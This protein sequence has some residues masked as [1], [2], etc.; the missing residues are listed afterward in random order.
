MINL[1]RFFENLFD[2][3]RI[4]DDNI[5]KFSNDHIQ[6]LVAAN[7]DGNLTD[8]INATVGA[9]TTYFG[10][11]T[12]EDT[13]FALQQARTIAVDKIIEEFKNAVSQHEGLVR[14]TFGKGTPEYEEFFPQGITEYR[15][16]TKQNLP[17]L[18]KRIADAGV[19]YQANWAMILQ[20]CLPH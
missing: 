18:T 13:A 9:Y 2:T 8:M 11:I 3:D 12:D 14:S 4:S 20:N 16:A 17:T 5:R 1:K 6:R 19:K 7:D 15:Q 10:A